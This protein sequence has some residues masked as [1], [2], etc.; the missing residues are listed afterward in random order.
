MCTN[1]TVKVNEEMKESTKPPEVELTT[2][3]PKPVRTR[4]TTVKPLEKPLVD[5]LSD[6]TTDLKEEEVVDEDEASGE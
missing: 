1:C 5:D 6:L 4:A 2:V 3:S